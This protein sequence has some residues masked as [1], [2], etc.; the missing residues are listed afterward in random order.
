MLALSIH[1]CQSL[2]NHLLKIGMDDISG[3]LYFL[4]K[5]KILKLCVRQAGVTQQL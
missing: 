5:L 2:L 4:M 3:Q 1:T